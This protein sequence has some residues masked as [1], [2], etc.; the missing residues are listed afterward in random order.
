MLASRQTGRSSTKSS[1]AIPNSS[2]DEKALVF[3]PHGRDAFVA[4]SLLQ[5]I[6]IPAI[7]CP[8]LDALTDA[9]GAEIALVVLSEEAVRIA[10]LSLLKTWFDNQPPWSDL[11]FIVMTQKG[12][13][14]ESNPSAA[15][16]AET[17]GNLVFL[18]RPFHPTTFASIARTAH[19]ARKRQYE[20]RNRLEDLHESQEKLAAAMLAGKLGSWSIDIST[21]TLVSSPLCRAIYGLSEDEK[22]TYARLLETIHPNDIDHMQRAGERSVK[23]GEDCNIEYR[24]LWPDGSVRWVQVNGRA[25]KDTSGA[26]RGV[27]GV[28]MDVT[29]RKEAEATLRQSN[30]WLER[31]VAERTAE[32]ERSHARV[33]EQ[34]QQREQVED[35]LRQAQKMEVIGQ[36]TGGIAHD[37]NN[38]LMAVLSNLDLLRKHAPED[39]R[40]DRLIEGAVQGAKRGAALTQ[41][42]LAFA[43]RQSLKVDPARIGALVEGIKTLLERSVGA[44]IELRFQIADSLPMAMIDSNQVEL[45]LLN[46]V[47]NARDAM[48]GGGVITIAADSVS[49]EEQPDLKAGRYVRLSVIDTGVGMNAETL[50]RA[51]EPSFSTKELGKGTGLGLSMIHGLAVQQNGALRLSSE[52]GEGTRAE[53]YL[54]STSLPA[55]DGEPVAAATEN[56]EHTSRAR[57]LLVDDD[58]LIAM[59]TTGMLED[60]GHEVIEAN[61]GL[62]ALEALK[63]NDGV[64]LV[65]TDFSMPGMNGAQLAEEVQR[66]KPGLPILLATGYAEMPNGATIDLPRLGKPYSQVEL[67]REISRLLSTGRDRPA[68]PA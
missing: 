63:V 56:P 45:A 27:V 23:D 51:I 57:I 19:K 61:S 53:I 9:L 21:E 8:N 59:S 30:E 48:P 22:L 20:A 11:P 13:G 31:R 38:L 16:L 36:L 18:E 32:L 42:L 37:F 64:D 66:L 28:V 60:L 52:P 54:P 44:D 35:Q 62:T 40:A 67:A 39:T 68:P 33:M 10:D 17:L 3:A 25:L 26:T 46:L 49:T 12:G 29:D 15:R 1:R 34:V 55:D 5:E 50:A 2:G 6:G 47:V 41:R 7:A 24:V 43:R 65:I 58:V 14:P 4:V